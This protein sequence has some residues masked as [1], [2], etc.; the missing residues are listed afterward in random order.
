[1][2]KEK[3][4]ETK[5]FVYDVLQ[6]Y[7]KK[8]TPAKIATNDLFD[9]ITEVNDL[10]LAM[11]FIATGIFQIERNILEK[12][13]EE[14]LTYWIYQFKKGVFNKDISDLELMQKD[15]KKIES[16]IKLRFKDLECYEADQ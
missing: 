13:I 6:P 16:L 11:Y 1:M 4:L 9:E 3:Y 14:Q 12:R 5:E 2:E 7:Y 15:V 10:D 8:N